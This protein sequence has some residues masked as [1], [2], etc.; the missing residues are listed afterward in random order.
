MRYFTLLIAIALL[1]FA[2][3][4]TANNIPALISSHFKATQPLGKGIYSSMGL[5]GYEAQLWTDAPAFTFAKPFALRIQYYW[6][7]D[8]DE[9]AERSAKELKY[10]GIADAQIQYYTPLMQQAFP[11]VKKNDTIT[12][13]YDPAGKISFYHNDM[14]YHTVADAAFAKDFLNI[15]LSDKT[16]APSLRNALLG[17]NP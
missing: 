8:R 4:A 15:W 2:S 16:S 10:I 11:N 17:S 1:A 7:F 3:S 6:N 14:L 5:E 12:A 13:I 9:I